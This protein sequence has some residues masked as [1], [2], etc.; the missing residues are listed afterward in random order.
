MTTDPLS[1][2]GKAVIIGNS[3]SQYIRFSPVV[4]KPSLSVKLL[5][6]VPTWN[7]VVSVLPH[8][9]LG[10]KNSQI[11]EHDQRVVRDVPATV[12]VGRQKHPSRANL[13][14]HQARCALA[15]RSR[16]LWVDSSRCRHSS[17]LLCKACRRA[18]W[19][20]QNVRG[21]GEKWSLPPP[22]E[23]MWLL[24]SKRSVS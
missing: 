7:L 24:W 10:K 16:L 4:S 5:H 6:S 9:F 1:L 15:E 8:F 18:G 12:N 2:L 23:S 19:G 22:R 17:G 20:E 14:V 3:V 11:R 21:A 13:S